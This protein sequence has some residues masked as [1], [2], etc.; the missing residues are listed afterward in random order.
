[1]LG[2]PG[3]AGLELDAGAPPTY[4]RINIIM[5]IIIIIIIIIIMKIIIMI[6]KFSRRAGPGRP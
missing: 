3:L 5:I 4:L 2:G 1:M 6:I